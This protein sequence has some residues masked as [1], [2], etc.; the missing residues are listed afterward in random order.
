M[1]GEEFIVYVASA[2]TSEIQVLR[3]DAS[4]GLAPLAAVPLPGVTE[5]GTS[6]PLAVSPDQRFLYAALRAEPYRAFAFRVRADGMLDPI[7]EGPLADTMAYLATDRSGRFLL[8]ASYHGSK[9][10]VNGIGADGVPGP[11][12]Q[13]IPTGPKAHAILA[14]AGNGIVL[15]TSLGAD[16]LHRYRF[17]AGTGQLMEIE[18]A[19]HSAPGA[20]PRHFTFHP[21]GRFVFVV[22]ELA[23]TV[24][25]FEIAGGEVPFRHVQTVPA[26]PDGFDGT[27]WAADIHVTPDG[28]LLYASER[29]SSHLFAYRIDAGSG[30][31]EP[32]GATETETQPRS[33]AID[34]AGRFLVAAGEVSNRVTCYAIDPA[35]GGLTARSRAAAGKTPNWVEIIPLP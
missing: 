18:P 5:H 1:A 28:A 29:T 15:A 3:L 31:L 35:S 25:A 12:A 26:L 32:L 30:R 10:A 21:N 4:G 23:A 2:G 20:G 11:A 22:N 13:V 8:G 27:P 7:G 6:M 16:R 24:D 34:P 17:D 33:F 14:D 19:A 9:V